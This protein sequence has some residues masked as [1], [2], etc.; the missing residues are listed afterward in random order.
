MKLSKPTFVAI[1][2]S[3]PNQQTLAPVDEVQLV[4]RQ[5]LEHAVD[6][7]DGTCFVAVIVLVSAL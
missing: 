3:L 6:E 5:L 4:W 2:P 1:Y 7:Y